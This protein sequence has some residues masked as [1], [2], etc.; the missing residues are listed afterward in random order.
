MTEVN[1]QAIAVASG[2]FS[3]LLEKT[4]AELQLR[5]PQLELGVA[6]LEAMAERKLTPARAWGRNDA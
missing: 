4:M 2:F 5:M 3:K 1:H 6:A